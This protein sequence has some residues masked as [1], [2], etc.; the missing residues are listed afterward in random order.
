MLSHPTF[1]NAIV[2]LDRRE[3][4]VRGGEIAMSLVS[5]CRLNL[6][7]RSCSSLC[8]DTRRHAGSDVLQLQTI[9]NVNQSQNLVLS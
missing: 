8:D 2:A 6:E 1:A 7:G 4:L 3:K 9:A 5:V